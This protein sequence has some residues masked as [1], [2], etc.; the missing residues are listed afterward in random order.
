MG[1]NKTEIDIIPIPE[2]CRYCGSTVVFTSNAEIYGKEYG[3][4]KCYLCRNCKAFVGVH[5][6]TQIP[7]G[8]LA[9]NELRK[10]RNK[11]HIEFDK[12]WKQPTR[13]MTRFNAYKWLA[14]KMN[15]DIKD[16]HIA[17]FEIK[18]CEKVIK[19]IEQMKMEGL[20]EIHI[21]NKR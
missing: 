7:L 15:K 14:N 4:G 6:G 3:N 1:R 18:E 17:L 20:D 12:L 13:I 2:T 5:T 11:A 21:R 19:L 9:N 10:A 8:T 16:T